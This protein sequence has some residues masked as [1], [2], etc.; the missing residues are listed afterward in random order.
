MLLSVAAL[1]YFTTFRIIYDKMDLRFICRYLWKAH[2]GHKQ[3]LMVAKWITL[4]ALVI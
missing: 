3:F 2:L 1:L 4:P